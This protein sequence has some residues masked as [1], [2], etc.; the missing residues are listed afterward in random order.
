MKGVSVIIPS[1]NSSLYIGESIESVLRQTYKNIEIIVVDDGSSDD[2]CAILERYAETHPGIFRYFRQQ[3][4][5]PG[6]ARN[7]GIRNAKGE[8]IAFN[9]A[10]DLWLPQKLEKQVAVLERNSNAVAVYCDIYYIDEDRSILPERK[11]KLRLPRGRVTLDM[12]YNYF[13]YTSSVVARRSAVERTGGFREDIFVGEDYHY[14]LRMSYD[15]EIDLVD[16]KLVEKRVLKES[17]SN[18]DEMLNAKND[19][20][21]YRDFLKEHPEFMVRHREALNERLH[22]YNFEL[23]YRSYKKGKNLQSMYYLFNALR[24]RRSLRA[25]KCL[26][27]S[28]FP[29]DFVRAVKERLLGR[30]EP[31]EE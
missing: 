13:M 3:N 20:I 2:T 16:E 21:I 8:Y 30:R 4:R 1:F 25:V 15:G 28:P 7:T 27:I 23:G 11:T 31:E 24:Y 17:L 9:D 29:Y 26:M 14:F 12:F 18:K 6:A 10:D 19:L 5:G 22:T